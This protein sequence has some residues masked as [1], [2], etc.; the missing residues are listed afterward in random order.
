VP[1]EPPAHPLSIFG[2]PPPDTD[3]PPVEVPAPAQ[4]DAVAAEPVSG[5]AA[6]ITGNVVD[7]GRGAGTSTGA[8][9]PLVLTIAACYL[10]WL[11]RTPLTFAVA[12]AMSVLTYLLSSRSSSGSSQAIV[13]D[14]VLDLRA[15][16][17]HHRFDLTNPRTNIEVQGSPRDRRWKVRVHRTG[18]SPYVI[19]AGKVDPTRFMQALREARPRQ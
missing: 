2:G 14:G 11:E 1:L 19:D 5:P 4:E 3:A 17:S 13:T 6:R 7:V 12:V 9:L 10:A 16:D 8:F 15:G 18:L